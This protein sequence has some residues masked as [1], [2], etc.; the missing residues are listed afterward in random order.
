MH[1]N[2]MIDPSTIRGWGIDADKNNDPT[3]PMR[4]IDGDDKTGMNWQRPPQQAESVEILQSIER[5]T[6]PAVFG[7]STPP[8][9]ISGILR[10]FAFRYSESDWIHWL[11]LMAADR[12][13]VVEGLFQDLGRLKVPNIPEEMGLRSEIAYNR[14]GLINKVAISA[15]LIGLVIVAARKR[16]ERPGR[17]RRNRARSQ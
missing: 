7:T 9:G 6:R 15:A 10:R 11:M 2:Q 14:G 13:N 12:V 8:S 16:P 5:N 4:D 1:D 17:R 3:Y